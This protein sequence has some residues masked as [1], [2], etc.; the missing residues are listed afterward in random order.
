MNG[1]PDAPSDGASLPSIDSHLNGVHAGWHPLLLQVH[2]DL[3]AVT[4][5]FRYA[6]IKEKYGTLRC[7]ID[8]DESVS[9][10]DFERC[11]AIVDEAEHASARICEFCGQPGTVR[12]D[13]SWIKTMCDNE[14][15]QHLRAKDRRI[16]EPRSQEGDS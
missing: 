7:Y 14:Y 5:N 13:L 15:E 10:T 8:A 6:Q 2:Q 9:D 11:E 12:N 4:T 1:H 16:R 3:L